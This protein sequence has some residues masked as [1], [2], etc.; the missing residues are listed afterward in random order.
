MFGLL[1]V[2]A[3][4]VVF[5]LGASGASADS[6]AIPKLNVEPGC[7]AAAKMGDSLDARLQ[8]CVNGEQTARKEL[9]KR[10]SQFSA[11]FKPDCIAT[12]QIGSDSYVQLLECLNLAQDADALRKSSTTGSAR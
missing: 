4:T 12:A 9:E 3:I 6:T 7:R 10:W 5:M 11:R 2:L 1:P 8:S